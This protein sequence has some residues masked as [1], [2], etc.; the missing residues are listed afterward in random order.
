VRKKREGVALIWVVL[1]SALILVSIIGISI[2]VVPEKQILNARAYSQRVLAVAETGLAK[3]VYQIRTDEGLQTSL[4]SLAT[5]SN[6]TVES[7][8]DS[9]IPSV[10]SAYKVEIVKEPSDEYSFYSMGVVY[11]G[12]TKTEANVIARKVI[13]VKYA[14]YFPFGD[15]ALFSCG[16]I[17]A[18]NGT[19]D[20]SIFANEY[21]DFT[22]ADLTGTAYCPANDFTGIPEDQQNAN[23]KETSFPSVDLDKYKALWTAFLNGSFPYC[24]PTDI[25][26]DGNV[27]NPDYPNTLTPKVHTYIFNKLKTTSDPATQD[28]FESFFDDLR[29]L[30][31]LEAAYLSSFLNSGKLIYYIKPTHGDTVTINGALYQTAPFLEGVMIVE[32]KL[33]LAGGAQ[34]GVDPYKTSILV[35]KTVDVGA[36]GATIKGFLYIMNSDKHGNEPALSIKAT[37]SFTCEGSIVAIGGISLNSNFLDIKWRENEIY[38]TEI[39]PDITE[40]L[41]PKLSPVPSSWQEVSYDKFQNP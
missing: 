19:V 13:K 16:G 20:G 27:D 30:T 38:E 29:N 21:I 11:K 23:C 2:K 39:K 18:Q 4:A 3:V 40:G 33:D 25:D 10:T 37:G 9:G 35:T 26:G 15:Y 12:S 17:D 34:I 36:G 24:G 6:I 8:F 5:G 31:S 32:G 28:D 1:M 14:G 41:E 7:D 22:H